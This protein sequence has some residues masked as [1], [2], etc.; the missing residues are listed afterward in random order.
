MALWVHNGALW[1]R[2][3]KMWLYKS[4]TGWIQPHTIYAHNGSVW[5]KIE[6]GIVSLTADTQFHFQVGAPVNMWTGLGMRATSSI[7]GQQYE[8][9]EAGSW[10]VNGSG[11]LKPQGDS[12]L[13]DNFECKLIK[14]GGVTTPSGPALNTWWGLVTNREWTMNLT[15]YGQQTFIGSIS[16]REI[17]RPD[18]VAQA[19]IDWTLE[20]ESGV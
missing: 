19:N 16:V 11:W 9:T 6:E 15:G 8:M 10:V 18:N 2:I 17:A 3:D 5:K 1:K 12:V 13:A 7:I 4:G 20:A 14:T